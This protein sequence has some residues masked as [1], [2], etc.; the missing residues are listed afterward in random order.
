MGIKGVGKEFDLSDDY[1]LEI[2]SPVKV[3]ESC[4]YG[5][6]YKVNV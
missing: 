4:I 6:A 2:I 5:L 3:M 1:I